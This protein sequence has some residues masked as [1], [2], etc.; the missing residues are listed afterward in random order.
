[1]YIQNP[2]FQSGKQVNDK[3]ANKLDKETVRLCLSC[4]HD[5]ELQIRNKQNAYNQL[6][7]DQCREANQVDLGSEDN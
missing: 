3:Y 5:C 6:R 2:R 1:M 4:K 7:L